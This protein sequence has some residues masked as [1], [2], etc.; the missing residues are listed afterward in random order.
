MKRV[1]L[2]LILAGLLL[3]GCKGSTPAP[4]EAV[5]PEQEVEQEAEQEVIQAKEQ[6]AENEY[7]NLAA[8]FKSVHSGAEVD[9]KDRGDRLEVHI[10]CQDLSA[11]VKPE[12]WSDICSSAE[13]AAAQIQSTANDTYGISNISFQI[14]DGSGTILGSGFA[15]GLQYDVFA[16]PVEDTEPEEES[17]PEQQEIIVYITPTG[18]KYHY[19]SN[20]GNGDY[21]PTTLSDAQSLG[22]SPCKK[23]AGG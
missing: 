12:N 2:A 15:S 11:D 19:D 6:T 18:S 9:V 23:C 21:S 14:E 20:C 16:E 4:D 7:E 17:D 3:T 8:P 22:S 5:S 13:A 10:I 1:I